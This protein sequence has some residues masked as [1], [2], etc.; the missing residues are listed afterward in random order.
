MEQELN[1]EIAPQYIIP[2]KSFGGITSSGTSRK[3]LGTGIRF[4]DASSKDGYGDYFDALTQ[5]GLRNGS[6]RPFLMEHWE[7]P[8]FAF[9][10]VGEAIYEK[11]SDG[12]EYEATLLDDDAGN[13]AYEHLSDP[14]KV[15]QSS[16]GSAWNYTKGIY[17]E[18]EAF[19][20]TVWLVLEQSATIK[21]ADYWNPQIKVKSMSDFKHL[22]AII[23]PLLEERIKHISGIEILE[24]KFKE[25]ETQITELKLPKKSLD[26]IVLPNAIQ[27]EVEELLN[28]AKSIK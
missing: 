11:K 13:L 3:V 18:S 17:T 16:T 27:L 25:L 23:A 19:L 26:S 8:T 2:I 20:M 4:G 5:T 12:W 10:V 6:D 21:P 9:K 15:Y 28:F 14:E 7:N 1:K 24:N 22:S